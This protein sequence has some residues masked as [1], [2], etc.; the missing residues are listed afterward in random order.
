[1]S[2]PNVTREGKTIKIKR[3]SLADAKADLAKRVVRLSIE[4]TLDDSVLACRD[5]L[6]FW[7]FDMTPIQ[8]TLKPVQQQLDLPMPGNEAT[9][10]ARGEAILE[11]LGEQKPEMDDGDENL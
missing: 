11:E 1:M 8:V 5:D 2:E 7:K 4:I 9:L 10:F 6:A 3:A